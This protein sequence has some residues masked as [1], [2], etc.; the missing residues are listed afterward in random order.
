MHG[1]YFACTT[2]EP[3]GVIGA[4]IPWNGPL[5]MAVWKIGP[6]LA[7]GRSIVV[8]PAK[9]ACLS[10]LALAEHFTRRATSRL[11]RWARSRL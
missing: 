9:D 6:A 1:E 5:M 7:T 10:V 2:R 8:K 11:R 4:I 3:L